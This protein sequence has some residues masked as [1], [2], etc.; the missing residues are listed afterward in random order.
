[1]NDIQRVPALVSQPVGVIEPL[2]HFG[3]EP[4]GDHLRNSLVL[5]PQCFG[6]LTQALAMHVLHRNEVGAVVLAQLEDL[7]DVGVLEDRCQPRLVEEHLDEGRIRRELRQDSLHH[8]VL[9]EARH[10]LASSQEDFSHSAPGQGAE[11][12]VRTDGGQL[13]GH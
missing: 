11:N 6:D 12:P 10:P 9:A 2:E 5:L 1:V 8:H 4:G 13:R 7:D 3:A